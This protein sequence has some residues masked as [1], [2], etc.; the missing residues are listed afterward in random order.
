MLGLKLIHA[1][2]R[3]PIRCHSSLLTKSSVY[4]WLWT[5]FIFLNSPAA[6]VPKPHD[7]NQN[8]LTTNINHDQRKIYPLANRSHITGRSCPTAF[9]GLNH[10]WL[11]DR[12]RSRGRRTRV[13]HKARMYTVT[14]SAT[15]MMTS[16]HGN[17]FELLA[18][19]YFECI[20]CYAHETW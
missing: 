10:S 3:G 7:I 11:A 17:A 8:E 2:K 19:C 6:I 1:R 12:V 14:N 16:S 5:H 13:G 4:N 9:T 15:N 18:F 20:T